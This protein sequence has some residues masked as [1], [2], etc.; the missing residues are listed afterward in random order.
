MRNL[1]FSWKTYNWEGA[2]DRKAKSDLGYY[3]RDGYNVG[4]W[5]MLNFIEY[6]QN[7]NV[8][9]SPFIFEG[10]YRKQV[11][12]KE[13]I[14]FLVFDFDGNTSDQDIFKEL[15]NS[16]YQAL[17]V[18]RLKM[19]CVP[20]SN[21]SPDYYKYRVIIP[22]EDTLRMNRDDYAVMMTTLTKGTS[23]DPSPL[24]DTAR[25]YFSNTFKNVPGWTFF[26]DVIDNNIIKPAWLKSMVREEKKR[27]DEIRKSQHSSLFGKL[28]KI[29]LKPQQELN[30]AVSDL[31]VGNCYKATGTIV[32][33]LRT[34]GKSQSDIEGWFS[35]NSGPCCYKKAITRIQWLFDRG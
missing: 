22:L 2:L 20:S 19:Y 5:P 11:N 25:F 28:K 21:W 35:K 6:I 26:E 23:V 33:I 30:N 10:G 24:K 18:R 14:D 32:G 31:Y 15:S 29:G 9:W 8:M 17:G 34:M 16:F 13:E 1:M 3:T 12:S 27:I 7:N 4:Y